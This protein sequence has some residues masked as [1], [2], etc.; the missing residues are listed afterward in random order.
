MKKYLTDWTVKDTLRSSSG[1]YAAIFHNEKSDNYVLAVRGSQ[2]LFSYEGVKDWTDDIIYSVRNEISSQMEEVPNLVGDYLAQNS[3]ILPRLSVTGHSLGGGLGI[4]ISNMYGLYA[5]TFDASPMLD[6]SYYRMTFEYTANFSGIDKWIYIDHVGEGDAIGGHEYDYKNAVKHKKQANVITTPSLSPAH[7]RD[8]LITIDEKN[9]EIEMSPITDEH[10]SKNMDKMEK[11]VKHRFIVADRCLPKGSLVM[12][13]SNYDSLFGYSG[14][15]TWYMNTIAVPHT[16]VMYGGDGDDVLLPQTGDDYIIGGKGDDRIYGDTGDDVYFYSQGDGTDTIIDS[17]GNDE[18]WLLNYTKEQLKKFK[19]DTKS[20]NNYILVYDDVGTLI[21]NIW[22]TSGTSTHS[23]DIKYVTDEKTES[24]TRLVDWNRVKSVRKLKFACPVDIG[25]YNGNGDLVTTLYDGEESLFSDD[26]GVYS[27]V[28]DGEEYVKCIDVSDESY[29]FVISG[30]DNGTM[31]IDEC[32]ESGDG[33][34]L[35][36]YTAKSVPVYKASTYKLSLNG[37][38]EPQLD[39]TEY[40]VEFDKKQYVP[41]LSAKIKKDNIRIAVEKGKQLS[42][43]VNPKNADNKNVEWA[44]M[45]ESIATVDEN[46]YV[47]GVAP[48]ETTV[49]AEIDGKTAVCTVNVAEKQFN[50]LILIIPGALILLTAVGVL[51]VVAVKRKNK[52][53]LVPCENG[54]HRKSAFCG[55]LKVVSGNQ[56]G[57]EYSLDSQNEKSVGK[58]QDCDIKLDESYKKVS[59]RHCVIKLSENG[60]GYEV[61]DTSSNGTYVQKIKLPRNE[62]AFIPAGATLLLADAECELLLL[63]PIRNN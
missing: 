14:D 56:F 12:G 7:S 55:R 26:N 21:F 35:T 5:E 28:Y 6:V 11:A 18:I 33:K 15:T 9:Q 44:S 53:T 63:P 27:V 59:R 38:D 54:Q 2:S 32:F 3:D 20:D 16:D 22:K 39:G 8:S 13:T 52:K 50:Y 46:G 23:M 49:V 62:F 41:V 1:F 51:I 37:D 43:S 60:L 48:G 47:K 34:L 61:M 45:D 29:S 10:Y 42:V 40:N 25:I 19:I 4:M 31:C 17:S 24:Y 57:Q 58:A 30:K 36:E